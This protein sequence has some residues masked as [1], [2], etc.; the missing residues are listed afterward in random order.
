MRHILPRKILLFFFFFLEFLLFRCWT[1]LGWCF[2]F[3][4]CFLRVFAPSAYSFWKISS[5]IFF[6]TFICTIGVTFKNFFFAFQTTT[7]KEHIVVVL[8][9]QDFL[10]F[11]S[12]MICF[13]FH[14]LCFH[15]VLFSFPREQKK[16]VII[17]VLK[18]NLVK[19]VGLTKGDRASTQKFH[20]TSAKRPSL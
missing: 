3:L 6:S 1:F 17:S 19:L 13:P 8:W 4:L 9:M 15:R 7:T 14:K 2:S 18:K 5:L 20:W 12:Q 11:S 10:F 16:S